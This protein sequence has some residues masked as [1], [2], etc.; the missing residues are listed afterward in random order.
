MTSILGKPL[1]H[2]IVGNCWVVQVVKHP[3]R[4][5]LILPHECGEEAVL[6]WLMLLVWHD[7]LDFLRGLLFRDHHLWV[8]FFLSINLKDGS[9]RGDVNRG[10]HSRRWRNNISSIIIFLL[11][12]VVLIVIIFIVILTHPVES[13]LGSYLHDQ[14]I[15]GLN[16]SLQ[17]GIL[18]L[19]LLNNFFLLAKSL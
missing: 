18:L 9:S 8:L 19:Q 15:A 13:G 5:L 1:I 6:R 11:I 16:H 3:Q 4:A 10:R 2:I 17:S 7:D 14:L 12:T